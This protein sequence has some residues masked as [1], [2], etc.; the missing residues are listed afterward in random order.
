[1]ELKIIAQLD[2]GEVEEIDNL[3]RQAKALED[4]QVSFVKAQMKTRAE[5]TRHVEDFWDGVYEKH[6]LDKT[7]N[8]R[9]AVNKVTG[10]RAIIENEDQEEPAHGPTNVGS[11]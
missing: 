11:A 4:M 10:E 7:K 2:P 3:N 9:V 8:Y 5:L 6:K 1:M